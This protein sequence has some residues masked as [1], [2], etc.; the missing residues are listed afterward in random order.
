MLAEEKG[1]NMEAVKI[2]DVDTK[3]ST[4]GNNLY[5]VADVLIRVVREANIPDGDDRALKATKHACTTSQNPQAS[6]TS[7]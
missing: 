6:P 1:I 2:D 5:T 4:Q 3:K 7:P